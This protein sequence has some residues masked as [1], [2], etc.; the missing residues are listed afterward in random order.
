MT[1]D[2]DPLW[3]QYRADFMALEHGPS[4]VLVLSPVEAWC[5]ASQIQL[6]T[7]HP[8]NTGE[9]R[10]IAEALARCILD[11]LATTPA[12]K[13]VAARG[14]DPAFDEEAR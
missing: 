1:H 14:W 12:L 7:R 4:L 10:R 6:A 9:S 5:L 3:S 11:K 8:A 2:D 13:M